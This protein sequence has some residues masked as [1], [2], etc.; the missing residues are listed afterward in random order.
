MWQPIHRT[1]FARIGAAAWIFGGAVFFASQFIAQA[2]WT[3]PYSW[4]TNAVSDLGNSYCLPWG[5]D[6]RY[7]CSPLHAVM[8]VS[9]ITEGVCIVLGLFFLRSLWRHTFF[10]RAARGLLLFAAVGIALAGFFPAD[11]SENWHV[12]GAFLIALLGPLGLILA[13]FQ[14]QATRPAYVRWLATVI[15]GIGLVATFLFFSHHYL[16]LGFGG[17]ERFWAFDL[18]VWTLAMGGYVLFSRAISSEF[19]SS[20]PVTSPT[21][22]N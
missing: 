7:V 11:V 9:L 5:E 6:H 15:G 2:A 8:N 4:A 20:S 3:T 22:T 18:S 21:S 10:S 17:M 19:T 14:L 13:G 1:Y 16:G 12:L